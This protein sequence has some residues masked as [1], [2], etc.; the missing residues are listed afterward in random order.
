[1]KKAINSI[2][3]PREG[4]HRQV[5]LKRGPVRLANGEV[6]ELMLFTN[7]FLL[8]TVNVD[9]LVGKL[10]EKVEEPAVQP[11]LQQVGVESSWEDSTLERDDSCSECVFDI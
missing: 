1:M 7:G 3:Y 9:Q 2:F 8:S 4:E 11:E 6:R 10:R 5:L